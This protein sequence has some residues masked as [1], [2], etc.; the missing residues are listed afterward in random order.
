MRL[1]G[2]R[3]A[4]TNAQSKAILKNLEKKSPETNIFE[5]HVAIEEAINGTPLSVGNQVNLLED[6]KNTY[7]AMLAA[8]HSA[9]LMLAHL[10][11]NDAAQRVLKALSEQSNAMSTTTLSTT[12]VFDESRRRRG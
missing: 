6:G 4:L 11:E 12:A 5:R 9:A 3:G 2:A 10:G 7:S 1:E 8:I